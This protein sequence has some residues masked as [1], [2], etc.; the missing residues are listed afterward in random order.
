[1]FVGLSRNYFH[2]FSKKPQKGLRNTDRW[3]TFALAFEGGNGTEELDRKKKSEKKVRKSCGGREKV[4]GL[5][6]QAKGI[7]GIG[8]K[9]AKGL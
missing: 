4:V 1:L 9:E 3:F 6:S 2:F 8:I 7:W 5:H